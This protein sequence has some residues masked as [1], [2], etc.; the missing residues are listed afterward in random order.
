MHMCGRGE[1][2]IKGGGGGG[3]GGRSSSSDLCCFK[4]GCLLGF[5]SALLAERCGLVVSVGYST[6][7]DVLLL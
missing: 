1:I 4:L 3:N 6:K 5:C 7:G 2:G